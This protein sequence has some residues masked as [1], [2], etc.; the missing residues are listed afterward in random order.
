MW[1][2][3]VDSRGASVGAAGSLGRSGAGSFLKAS[4]GISSPGRQVAYGVNTK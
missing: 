3:C 2:S 4:E 1:D